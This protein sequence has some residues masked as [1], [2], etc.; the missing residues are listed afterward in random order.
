M[1]HQKTRDPKL[2]K[3]NS[4][5]LNRS[6]LLHRGIME[7]T[8]SRPHLQGRRQLPPEA[9]MASSIDTSRIYSI[10][11]V[12]SL[13]NL[14]PLTTPITLPAICQ[15]AL[16][17]FQT[18]GLWSQPVQ[19]DLLHA[20]MRSVELLSVADAVLEA[21]G[22]ADDVLQPCCLS[23]RV[24]YLC[25]AGEFDAASGGDACVLLSAVSRGR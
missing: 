10:P 17:D 23:G 24:Y 7:T 21:L 14:G 5:P 2:K 12:T 16:Y 19:L 13:T 3:S 25:W 9:I 20:R 11:S 8:F 6:S 4:R 15:S 1:S 18:P 22:L